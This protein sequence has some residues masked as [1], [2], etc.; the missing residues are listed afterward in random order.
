[1]ERSGRPV[2]LNDIAI[3]VGTN[4]VVVKRWMNIIKDIQRTRPLIFSSKNGFTPN[5][6]Y[7]PIPFLLPALLTIDCHVAVT[8]FSV[9]FSYLL[10]QLM[11]L[12][13]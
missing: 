2:N 6:K 7:N 4:T 12:S 5:L 13:F 3:A 11:L 10:T 1:M 8:S 9:M